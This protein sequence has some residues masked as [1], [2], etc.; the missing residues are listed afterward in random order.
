M[1]I[2]FVYNLELD[3]VM[4]RLKLSKFKTL[5]LKEKYN[6]ED[7][8]CYYDLK[9]KLIIKNYVAKIKELVQ[10]NMSIFIN[11]QLFF[12]EFFEFFKS[13]TYAKVAEE[14]GRSEDY[15]KSYFYHFINDDNRDYMTVEEFTKFLGLYYLEGQLL[16]T[17][18]H[19]TLTEF[20]P[21]DHFI[22]KRTGCNIAL[23][24][25]DLVKLVYKGMIINFK[26]D[27]T[28]TAVIHKTEVFTMIQNTHSGKCWIT[29]GKKCKFFAK[30]ITK[31]LG[32]FNMSSGDRQ[33]LTLD[34][35]KLAYST[36]LFNDIA[37]E[38][39]K[40]KKFDFEKIQKRAEQMELA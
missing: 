17:E 26:W 36:M 22:N 19:P 20:F 15:A 27:T 35:G 23:A 10:G 11:N 29:A 2:Q 1:C 30:M 38:Q 14:L 25:W 37:Y 4:T 3:A 18:A 6:D 8:A 40:Q 32:F 16:V 13:G 5:A 7:I 12:Q 33:A 39:C 28:K 24:Y 9:Q 34:E 21:N 31:I